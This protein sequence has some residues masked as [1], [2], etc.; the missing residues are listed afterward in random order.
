M[1]GCRDGSVPAG[2][3]ARARRF[4]IVQLARE[5]NAEQEPEHLLLLNLC[6]ACD[7][8]SVTQVFDCDFAVAEIDPGSSSPL[9]ICESRAGPER[10]R[11]IV[12]PECQ[13]TWR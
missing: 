4:A 3:I 13:R 10:G 7:E 1:T 12:S 8:D 2:I 11:H 6:M 9:K 5:D